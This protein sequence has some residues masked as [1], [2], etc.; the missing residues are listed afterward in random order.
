MSERDL[1]AA[2]IT[3]PALRA[4]YEQCRRLNADH[5]KT[6]YLA[7]LLLP[8]AKRPHV[9]ALYGFARYADEFVDSL[10]DPHPEA[11]TPWGERFLADLE[12]GDSADPVC[13]AVINTIRTW[14]IPAPLFKAFLDSMAMDLTVTEYSTFEDLRGYM[15]G[16]AAVIGLQMLPILEPLDDRAY[17]PAQALG[18][19]FQLTNFIR[20]VA[21]D[22]DRGRVYLPLEDLDRFGVTREQLAAEARAGTSSRPVRDLVRFEVERC[23]ELYRAAA[24]GPLLLDPT[25]RDCIRTAAAL[26]GGI[27]DEVAGAGYDVLSARRAVPLPRRLRVAVPGLARA[28]LARRE[29]ASWRRLQ[30]AG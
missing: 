1:D 18:E 20:D 16:S 26:Y 27:L 17:A 14:D 21:E 19:A 9:H 13:R 30:T 23:R 24:H 6:Y 4:C 28:A 12:G 29:S 5:G 11:L 15:Y 2:G 8:A 7:T 10:Q 3:D 22:L 25:S